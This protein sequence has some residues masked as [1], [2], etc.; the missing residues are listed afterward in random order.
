MKKK[1]DELRDE[2]EEGK[3]NEGRTKKNF[4]FNFYRYLNKQINII[5]LID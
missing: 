4:I 1:G 5:K 2:Y 3:E